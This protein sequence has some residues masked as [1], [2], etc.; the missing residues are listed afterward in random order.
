MRQHDDDEALSL[1]ACGLLGL[2]FVLML[3]LTGCS[4]PEQRQVAS[5]LLSRGL[6]TPEQYETIVGGSWSWLWNT[7]GVVL[8][9]G[10]LGTIAADRLTT[11]RRG[12]ITAR[13][14]LPPAPPEPIEV[15]VV[16][17]V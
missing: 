4:T 2:V 1:L 16:R 9:G 6:I 10:T 3:L 7:L 12:P 13:K 14:G 5:D 11:I 17:D 15:A 8:G